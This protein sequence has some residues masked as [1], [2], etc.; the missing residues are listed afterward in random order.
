MN[1]LYIEAP[2]F[3]YSDKSGVDACR[4]IATAMAQDGKAAIGSIVL[5]T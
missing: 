2:H 4:V 1:Q 3:I 5:S